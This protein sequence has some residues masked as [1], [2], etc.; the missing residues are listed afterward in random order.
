MLHSYARLADADNPDLI[1][2]QVDEEGAESNTGQLWLSGAVRVPEISAPGT[3]AA[4]YVAIYAKSNGLLYSK[5]DTGAETLMSG[6]AGGSGDMLAANN[7]SD[8]VSD[9]T[10]LVNLITGATNRTPSVSTEIPAYNFS[11]AATSGGTFTIQ[12]LYDLITGLTA[13]TAPATADELALYDNVD[14]AAKSLTLGNLLNVINALTAETAPAYN[15]KLPLY[16]ASAGQTDAVTIA[17]LISS[18]MCKTVDYTGSGSSGKTVTLTGIN[19]AHHLFIV[20]ND[21]SANEATW[22]FAGG[23]TGTIRRM[24]FSNTTGTECSLNAAADGVA[25]TLTINTTGAWINASGVSYR[26]LVIGTPT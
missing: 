4:G 25:Q 22:W 8:L 12:Q 26:I 2:R 1:L 6:G 19:R 16:D 15:D 17:N 20:R 9:D 11:G 10:A 7:L 5:D 3:P 21:A 24:A 18:G 23:S 14:S 13:K